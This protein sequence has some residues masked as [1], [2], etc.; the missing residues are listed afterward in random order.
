M[1]YRTLDTNSSI[2]IDPIAVSV[3]EDRGEMHRLA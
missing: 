2:G 3:Y 1:L